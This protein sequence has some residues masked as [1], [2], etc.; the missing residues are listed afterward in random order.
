MCTPLGTA[1]AAPSRQMEGT[2]LSVPASVEW[3]NACA[4]VKKEAKHADARRSEPQ[5]GADSS[6]PSGCPGPGRAPLDDLPGTAGAV[7]PASR[8]GPRRAGAELQ[9]GQA[10]PQLHSQPEL[11]FSMQTCMWGLEMDGVGSHSYYSFLSSQFEDTDATV[12]RE[13]WFPSPCKPL[14]EPK[15]AP[16]EHAECDPRCN[17]SHPMMDVQ[18]PR[19]LEA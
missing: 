18:L 6:T 9:A 16:T 12:Q 7:P 14:P 11:E 17:L 4:A 15:T 8:T 5:D 2:T 1:V 19:V 10:P 3:L 13:W